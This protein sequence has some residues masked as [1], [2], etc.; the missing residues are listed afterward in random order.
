MTTT[1]AYNPT[2]FANALRR[3]NHATTPAMTT[4]IAASQRKPPTTLFV[5]EKE[6]EVCSILAQMLPGLSPP[7]KTSTSSSTSSSS[8]KRKTITSTESE[9]QDPVTAK[10]AKSN[11]DHEEPGKLVKIGR[12]HV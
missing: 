5:T 8:T 4:A 3:T 12:A 2:D 7:S 10:K 9:D 11:L 1:T 6:A